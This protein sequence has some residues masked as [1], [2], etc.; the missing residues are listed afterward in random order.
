M[1]ILTQL[2]T[3]PIALLW[4]EPKPLMLITLGL[5]DLAFQG[6]PSRQ[7]QVEFVADVNALR[8][9]GSDIAKM[10]AALEAR[11]EQLG[12]K[13]DSPVDQPESEGE[14]LS[15]EQIIAALQAGKLGQGAEVQPLVIGGN[16]RKGN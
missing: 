10:V 2:A 1:K 3:A 14:E 6:D 12:F 5:S 11:A 15:E 4:D 7:E 16:A 9:F 8:Q 13:L